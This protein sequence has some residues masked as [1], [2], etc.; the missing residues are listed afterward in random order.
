MQYITPLRPFT[1]IRQSHSTDPHN[2][3]DELRAVMDHDST[4]DSREQQVS[5]SNLKIWY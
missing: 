3:I 4:F 2:P 5:I 1:E